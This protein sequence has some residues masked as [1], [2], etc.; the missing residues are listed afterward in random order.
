MVVVSFAFLFSAANDTAAAQASVVGRDD[1]PAAVVSVVVAVNHNPI[2]R[3]A[4]LVSAS[5]V[6]EQSR[7]VPRA[8]IGVQHRQPGFASG[9]EPARSGPRQLSLLRQ[10]AVL[11]VNIEQ[12]PNR[13]LFGRGLLAEHWF[14]STPPCEAAG[15]RFANSPNSLAAHAGNLSQPAIAGRRL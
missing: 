1:R 9:I 12:L 10:A 2:V 3:C 4:K 8:A 5:R 11:I 15:E 14:L 7:V 13:D 6:R